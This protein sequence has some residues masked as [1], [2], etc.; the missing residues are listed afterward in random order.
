[1]RNPIRIIKSYNYVTAR[2]AHRAVLYTYVEVLLPILSSNLMCSPIVNR[3][4]VRIYD[5]RIISDLTVE[6]SYIY[7]VTHTIYYNGQA[8][9]YRALSSHGTAKK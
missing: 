7:I 2:K 1:M 6:R 3:S 5:K 8:V 9:S 4:R